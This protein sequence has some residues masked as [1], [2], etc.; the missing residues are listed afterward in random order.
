MLKVIYRLNV[1]LAVAFLTLTSCESGKDRKTKSG[2]RYRIYTSSSEPRIEPG[3]YITIDLLYRTDRDSVLFDSRQ[4]GEPLRFRLEKI[5][6]SGSYEEGLT[7]LGAGDSATFFVPADSL[8]KYLVK[9]SQLAQEA[10]VFRKGTFMKFDVKVHRVQDTRQGELEDEIRMAS[11][12]EEEKKLIENF[13]KEKGADYQFDSAGYYYKYLNRGNGTAVEDGKV[14]T[15]AYTG[16]FLDGK[17]FDSSE[18]QGKDFKFVK[19]AGHV[20]SGWESAIARSKVG[21]KLM[22]LLPSDLAYGETGLFDPTNGRL[23]VL[24]FTPLLFQIQIIKVEELVQQ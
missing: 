4:N 8:Y 1:L 13:I 9:D 15:A 10:T 22:L 11:A 12:L 18:A 7:Y 21:D 6:F 2:F 24:P 20:V 3:N 23:I 14:V 5:P 16:S 17:I 19:G